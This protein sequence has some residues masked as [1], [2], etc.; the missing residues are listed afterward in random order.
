MDD[1]TPVLNLEDRQVRA[2]AYL[3]VSTEDQDPDLQRRAIAAW[4]ETCG[5]DVE[6]FEEKVSAA[7]KVRPRYEQ[8]LV[9]L[10]GGLYAA[11]VCWRFD[12]AARSA[13]ELLALAAECDRHEAKF[14]SLT[15]GVDTTTVSG[16]LLL[17]IHGAFARAERR[18][19]SERVK[20]GMASAKA[21][22]KH[23]G[24]KQTV[25]RVEEARKLL[26]AG[27]S[28]RKVARALKVG[29]ATLTRALEA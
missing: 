22:G 29:R 24:R 9:G 25:V 7:A 10:R 4:A 8:M 5:A 15:E 6:W 20:A 13:T 12:R 16:E 26:A 23:L 3:R 28:F 27:S 19:L 21:R 1:I 18:I 14:I 17:T 11:V 2:A